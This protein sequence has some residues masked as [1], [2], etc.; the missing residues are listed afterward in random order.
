M[1][2]SLDI[3]CRWYF[4]SFHRIRYL[5]MCL[6]NMNTQEIQYV[7]LSHWGM[8]PIGCAQP[9]VVRHRPNLL[10]QFYPLPNTTLTIK[11][12]DVEA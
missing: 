2:S 6:P 10:S 11:N 1:D 12:W 7:S 3:G 4:L 9:Q 5:Y 8:F